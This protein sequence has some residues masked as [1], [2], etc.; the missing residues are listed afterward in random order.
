MS[1]WVLKASGRRGLGNRDA[2]LIGD[3]PF[4][5]LSESQIE[6]NQRWQDGRSPI[7]GT[8]PSEKTSWGNPVLSQH[9]TT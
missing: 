8:E 4:G 5:D 6:E 2:V 7:A 1:W 9:Q 3:P